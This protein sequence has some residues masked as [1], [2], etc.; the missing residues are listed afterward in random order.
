MRLVVV[1]AV[2]EIPA[3]RG[4]AL[5]TGL[6][7]R[8]AQRPGVPAAHHA[9]TAAPGARHATENVSAA[10]AVRALRPAVFAVR[11]L[12]VRFRVAFAGVVVV[13]LAYVFRVRHPGFGAFR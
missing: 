12:T 9:D 11:G 13:H 6:T 5:V 3:T 7:G 8:G 1:C 4:L 10:R 2:A